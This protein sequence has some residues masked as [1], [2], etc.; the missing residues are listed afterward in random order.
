M[1]LDS[2]WNPY[3]VQIAEAKTTRKEFDIESDTRREVCSFQAM[4]CDRM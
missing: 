1:T 4:K 2:P 3:E